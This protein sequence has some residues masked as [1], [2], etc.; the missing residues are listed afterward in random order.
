[1][2][3]GLAQIF[4]FII[5]VHMYVQHKYYQGVSIPL[6]INIMI[7]LGAL[8]GRQVTKKNTVTK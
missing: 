1:M 3:K 5:V 6:W 2:L 4:V 8:V 7:I